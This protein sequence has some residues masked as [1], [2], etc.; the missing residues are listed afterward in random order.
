MIW[1]LRIVVL[2]AAPVFSF[3]ILAEPTAVDQMINEEEYM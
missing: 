1:E 3:F 2:T